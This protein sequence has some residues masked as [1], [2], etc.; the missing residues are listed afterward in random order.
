MTSQRASAEASESGLKFG[1]AESSR[2]FQM[3]LRALTDGNAVDGVECRIH[4]LDGSICDLW[5]V[6]QVH[7]IDNR[8]LKKVLG[9]AID[10]TDRKREEEHRR[11]LSS[12]LA[13]AQKME[14]IGRLAGGVAHDFNNILTVIN[15]YSKLLQE[16]FAGGFR[17]VADVVRDL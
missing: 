12:Q 3:F 15:G 4:R 5:F 16:L 9:V 7:S 11:L 2:R 1:D 8:P 6:G 17:L 14:A 13:Q 10:I